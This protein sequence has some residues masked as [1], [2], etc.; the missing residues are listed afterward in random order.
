MSVT[1]LVVL[2]LI[3]PFVLFPVVFIWYLNIGGLVVAARR[4]RPA[5]PRAL[6]RVVKLVLALAPPLAVYA[7]GIWF[8]L[9]KSGWQVALAVGIVLPIILLP[10]VLVWGMVA[11]GL[12]PALRDAWRRREAAPR[13]TARLVGEPAGK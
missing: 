4:V 3:I 7:F 10:P 11:G 12:S 9:G 8:A 5:V 6:L 2:A 13:E 1:V